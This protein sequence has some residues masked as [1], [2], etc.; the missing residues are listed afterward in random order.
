MNSK[1]AA[2]TPASRCPTNFTVA[3]PIAQDGGDNTTNCEFHQD[4][5]PDPADSR[6]PDTPRSHGLGDKVTRRLLQEVHHGHP[7]TIVC[8]PSRAALFN[9]RRFWIAQLNQQYCQVAAETY[10][11]QDPVSVGSFRFES[12]ARFTTRLESLLEVFDL[13]R[14]QRVYIQWH[15]INQIMAIRLS[16]PE[17]AAKLKIVVSPTAS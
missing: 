17:A 13:G 5:E 11:T 9:A 10:Q 4:S 1:S 7:G 6:H 2:R 14:Q 16:L 12:G 15:L 8:V 3:Q